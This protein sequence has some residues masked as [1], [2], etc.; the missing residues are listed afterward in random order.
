MQPAW[1][2]RREYWSSEMEDRLAT[3]LTHCRI[4]TTN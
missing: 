4:N 3:L 1:M 2:S